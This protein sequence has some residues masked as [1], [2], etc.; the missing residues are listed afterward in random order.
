MDDLRLCLV[1]DRALCP[2]VVAV[3]R[4]CAEAGLPAVQLREKDLSALDLAALARR[5][6]GAAP[7]RMLIVNDRLDVAL[8]VDADAVQRT[9]ASLTVEDMR[10]AAGT[11]V[12]ISASVHSRGEAVQAEADGA[13]WVVFGPVYDTP[14]KRHFGAPQGPAALEDVASALRIPV[15][16]IGG[17]VPSR[18]SELLAA[19]AA[20]VCVISA[21]MAAPSPA[22]ATREFLEAIEKCR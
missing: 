19:G 9:A 6:R 5:V 10:R 3:V 4:A 13:D 2:D 16:A 8:A 20:G 17:I 21:I 7:D 18:V 15:L 22:D 12:L 1:T 11:R 14:S